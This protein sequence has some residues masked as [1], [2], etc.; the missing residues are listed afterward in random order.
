VVFS[1]YAGGGGGMARYATIIATGGSSGQSVIQTKD[2]T[3][4]AVDMLVIGS[5]VA[6]N[7]KITEIKP[8]VSFT[9]DKPLKANVS[10]K[11]SANNGGDKRTPEERKWEEEW[12]KAFSAAKDN[13]G[14]RLYLLS[15]DRDPKGILAECVE[16]SEGQIKLVRGLKTTDPVAA[17]PALGAPA[18]S[19]MQTPAPAAT[20][21]PASTTDAGLKGVT[22]KAGTKPVR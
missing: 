8:N 9:L 16:A 21:V 5:G 12:I 2:T 10:G 14:P 6:P 20:T 19:I 4:L 13:K 18:G 11:I 17:K 15:I 3:D 22:T 1:N 7:S